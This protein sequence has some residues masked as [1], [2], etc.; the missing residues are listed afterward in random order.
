MC[1]VPNFASLVIRCSSI[2]HS[3]ITQQQL[4]GQL[5]IHFQILEFEFE[6]IFLNQVFTFRHGSFFDI[7]SSKVNNLNSLC[8]FCVMLSSWIKFLV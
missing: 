3:F 7:Q 5:H 4:N 6:Y 2:V 1:V 8:V